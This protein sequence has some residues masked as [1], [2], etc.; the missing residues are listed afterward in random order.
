[1]IAQGANISQLI[2]GNKLKAA[3]TKRCLQLD[4]TSDVIDNLRLLGNEFDGT[5]GTVTAIEKI[6][7]NAITNTQTSGNDFSTCAT[8]WSNTLGMLLGRNTYPASLTNPAGNLNADPGSEF[9]NPG[10]G[11]GTT[12]YVKESTTGTGGWVGK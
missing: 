6:G 1:M 12:L 4:A 5:E 2:Q 8:L 3:A 9:W 7:A 11:A 10:G